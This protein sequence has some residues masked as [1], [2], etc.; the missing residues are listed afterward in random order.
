M[1]ETIKFLVERLDRYNFITNMLPGAILC[2]VLEHFVGYKLLPSDEWILSV[3]VIYFVGIVN[4]RFGS[5]VVEPVLRFRDFI[6]FAPYKDYVKAEKLD[7]KIAILNADNNAFRS[8]ASVFLLS[9]LAHI[10][11]TVSCYCPF[12]KENESL[13]LIFSLLVLFVLAYRKQTE[14]IR[15]RVETSVNNRG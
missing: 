11:K 8:Y 3:I 13:M 15:Q 9:L 6:K 2:M 5:L 4:S 7:H 14:Y 1:D 12:F 10:F